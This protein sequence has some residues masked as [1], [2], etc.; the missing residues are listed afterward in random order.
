MI[1][2]RAG[3]TLVLSVD[4][5][6]VGWSQVWDR[7]RLKPENTS[8]SDSKSSEILNIFPRTS[9]YVDEV[10]VLIAFKPEYTESMC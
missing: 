2:V 6:E 4:S 7:P 1:L 5:A 3:S 9:L 8:H 10:P